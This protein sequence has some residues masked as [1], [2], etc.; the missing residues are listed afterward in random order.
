M[1]LPDIVDDLGQG[2]FRLGERNADMLKLAGK[3][4]S[5]SDLTTRLLRI[6]GVRDA[7]V[8]VPEPRPGCEPRPAALVVAP[9][10]SGPQ[11]LAALQDMIDPVFL[12]RP[13][14]RLPCLPRNAV[15]KLPRAALIAALGGALP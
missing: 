6:P 4:A 14:I 7:V 10:M 8:F 11:I 5:L 1:A 15:G 3:R 13:L 12:P 9:D 2:R